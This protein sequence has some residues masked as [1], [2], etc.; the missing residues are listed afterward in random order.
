M[1]KLQCV[2]FCCYSHVIWPL[3]SAPVTVSLFH[4][5]VSSRQII[6][7]TTTDLQKTNERGLEVIECG[8]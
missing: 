4:G 8:M 7:Q 6:F 3:F 2:L 1:I 5:R